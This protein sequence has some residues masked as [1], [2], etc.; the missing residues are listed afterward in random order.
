MG[1]I[2]KNFGRI[3]RI[4]DSGSRPKKII[5]KTRPKNEREI[6]KMKEWGFS[7][8][9]RNFNFDIRSQYP[10]ITWLPVRAGGGVTLRGRQVGLGGL[11]R[12]CSRHQQL[13]IKGHM[14]VLPLQGSTAG[15]CLS[16]HQ[17]HMTGEND[18]LSARTVNFIATSYTTCLYGQKSIPK[19]ESSIFGNPKASHI[20]LPGMWDA[21]F[22]FQTKNQKFFATCPKISSI[23]DSSHLES[24]G[25]SGAHF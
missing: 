4:L 19:M 2:L 20:H 17:T 22:F 23:S 16:S 15:P 18:Q 14:R 1:G 7:K 9:F 25:A 12:V 3:F 24:H 6:E 5:S 13:K 8:I 10:Q 11:H 21:S